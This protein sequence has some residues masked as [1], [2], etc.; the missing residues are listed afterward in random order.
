MF[1]FRHEQ[2]QWLSPQ[3]PQIRLVMKWASRGSM[4]FMKMS[5][6]R[7]SID[8]DQHFRTC[9]LV[10][11]ISVWM[12]SDPTIRVTGS[13]DISLTVTFRSV[14]CSTVAMGC[15]SPTLLVAGRELR[16]AVAPRR[17]LV[18]L[19]LHVLLPAPAQERSVGE[20]RDVGRDAAHRVLVHE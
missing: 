20:L 18:V 16:A 19:A 10:K 13:H 5:K 3:M 4:P 6:P 14:G 9:W 2:V 12:P 1:W 11:S 7:K 15:S 8:V 17:L